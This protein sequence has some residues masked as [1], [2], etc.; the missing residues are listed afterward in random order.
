[1]N[2]DDCGACCMEVGAPPGYTWLM[3]SSPESRSGWPDKDDIERAKHL[4]ADARKAILEA[5]REDDARPCCW[6]D[7]ENRRC[8]FYE[9]RPQ[10]CRDYELGSEDCLRYRE[11][12]EIGLSP[13]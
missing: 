8:R 1:M 9:H 12:Y 13:T 5:D 4:P 6:L 2:C 7:V 11:V 10:I 3:E